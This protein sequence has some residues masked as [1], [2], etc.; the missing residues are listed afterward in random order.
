[1]EG[2]FGL[3]SYGIGVW[4]DTKLVRHLFKD[5]F[6]LSGLRHFALTFLLRIY[7]K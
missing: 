2:V 4:F 1:M 6:A 7:N 3:Y 5:S